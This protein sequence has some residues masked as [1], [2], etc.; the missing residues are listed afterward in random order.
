[1]RV[2]TSLDDGIVGIVGRSSDTESKSKQC[3]VVLVGRIS[4]EFFSLHLWLD[5][6]FIATI[7]SSR[8]TT[9]QN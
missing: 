3:V 1:M 6:H 8:S 5:M 2:V 7:V 4:G 9:M